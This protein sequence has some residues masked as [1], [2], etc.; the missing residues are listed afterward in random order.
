MGEITS[1]YTL[2]T[3]QLLDKDY[4]IIQEKSASKNYKFNYIPPGEYFI[5][6]MIDANKNGKWDAGNILLNELPEPI[7][8][9]KNEDGN[10]K[11]TMRVDFIISLDLTF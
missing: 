3:I 10:S 1:N 5:R 8:I 11:T 4:T 2:Y 6:I 7:I 9:Y